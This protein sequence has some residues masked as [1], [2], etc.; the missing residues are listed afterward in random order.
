MYYMTQ[1]IIYI[2]EITGKIIETV[3]RSVV[4]RVKW[5]EG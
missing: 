3:R 5:K 2:L 4:A 1:T